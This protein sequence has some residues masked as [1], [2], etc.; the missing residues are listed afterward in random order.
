M[1]TQNQNSESTETQSCQMAVKSRFFAQYYG[2]EILRWHQWTETTPNSKVDLS[3]PAIEKGGW[4][5]NLK[6]LPKI[7][8]EEAKEI[9]RIENFEYD[10]VID[11]IVSDDFLELLNDI[12]LGK[13]N[14]FYVVD[15][16][17]SKG[18][19][20]PFIEYSVEDLVSFGWVQLL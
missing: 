4:F 2:Q 16:L 1:K 20:I 8:D 14:K 12:K 18:Y 11:I 6:K 13:C 17:R 19:A 10:T 7:T 15:F 5:I 9:A 3:I